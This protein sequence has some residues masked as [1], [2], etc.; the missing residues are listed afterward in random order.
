MT[1]S[2]KRSQLD[3]TDAGNAEAQ[4]E[5]KMAG[6][7]GTWSTTLIVLAFLAPLGG[8]VG[9][10]PL[11]VGF[12]NG[13][14]TPLTYVVVG[15]VLL[16]FSI[17]YTTLVRHVARPGAFYAYVTAGLGK[18][19]GLG[20][21]LLTLSAYIVCGIGFYAF[22]GF[23]IV[24]TV[25]TMGGPTLPWW[26]GSLALFA[27]VATLSYRGADLNVRV[28]ITILLTE[29]LVIIVFDIVQ[30]ATRGM[31]SES[32]SVLSPSSLAHGSFSAA[33]VFGFILY[34]GFEVSAV[35]SE[36]MRD[37]TRTVARATYATV[38]TI[39]VFYALSAWAYILYF[40]PGSAA[41]TAA[42]NPAGS[43]LVAIEGSLGGTVKDIVLVQLLTSVLASELSISNVTARYIFS[44]G[45]DRVLPPR[46]GRV[47][48][49][50]GAPSY[51]S[52]AG[53]SVF[54]AVILLTAVLGVDPVIVL[55]GMSG[56]SAIAF[57]VMLVLVSLSVITYFRSVT[58]P[59]ESRIRTLVAPALALVLIL[60]V[61]LYAITNVDQITGADYAPFA[62][63]VIAG[64]LLLLCGGM[65]LAGWLKRARPETYAR[66]G[67]SQS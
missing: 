57:L 29:A 35:Y 60:I 43:F 7:L 40:G 2:P 24:D 56:A 33:V 15:A 65:L 9:Y 39:T 63:S 18:H 16:I 11:S 61:L 25:A 31:S 21:S 1:S 59:G 20:S 55:S 28:M 42:E 44:L 67:R 10:I 54:V 47:H 22:G 5:A 49:K 17:G 26:L 14:G 38:V 51:A 66:I 46:L 30:F 6:R 13:I 50:T 52:V 62:Y 8:A 34:L 58:T 3:A 37:P 45:V 53:N 36:E 4:T 32:V 64:H 27:V 23:T 48:P 41:S 12:G 19:I